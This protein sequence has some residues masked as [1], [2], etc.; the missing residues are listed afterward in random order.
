MQKIKDSSRVLW[1]SELLNL[2]EYTQSYVGDV[3]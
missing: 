1:N 3:E 2:R